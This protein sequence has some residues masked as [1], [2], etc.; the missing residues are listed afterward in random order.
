MRNILIPVCAAILLLVAGVFILNAQLWYSLR[1][2]RLAGARYAAQNIATILNEAKDATR[3]AVEVS[4]R[5]CD[6]AGQYQLGTEAAVQPHLR[7]LVILSEEKVWCTSLPGNNV[8]LRHLDTIP[9]KELSLIPAKNAVDNRPVMLFQRHFAGKRIIVSVSDRNIRDAMNTPLR[10]VNYSLAVGNQ[11]MGM[12]GDITTRVENAPGRGTI[13]ATA[14]PFSIQYNLPP[15]FSASR[16]IHQGGGILI[17]LLLMSCIA[18]YALYKYLNKSTTPEESLRRA[19]AKGEIVPFYQP[20]MNGREGTVRGIEVL[21]RWKHP[22]A[23]FISPSVF[24]PA[25]EKSGLIVALTR[26]LMTQVVAHMNAIES[27]LPEGFHVGI[28][29]SASHITSPTFVAEC[30][31]YKKN[32]IRKDLNLVIEVTEREPLHVDEHLIQTLNVLHESGFT[33]ALDDFGTGYSG[34]SYLHDLHI[35]YIKIDQ[36][37]VGRVNAYK[38]STLILDSVLELARKL[39]ISIVAEGVET[40][41]QLDYLSRNNITFLQGYYFYKPVSLPELVK[42]L[43]SK[44]KVKVV[45][46]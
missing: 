42:I 29:F 40:Q 15:L 18:A 12:S 43:L 37:F 20:I 32:F 41:A 25:A 6:S 26:S 13:E 33:I 44:P 36:S 39:S 9:E 46:E 17:F 24:I 3:V 1:E 21:A 19:I 11:V 23:G 7:T 38:D 16:L 10:Y 30:L 22:K 2:D 8:L 4:T 5:G 35:D 31:E 14:Y 34:L 45:V 27:K 28:N